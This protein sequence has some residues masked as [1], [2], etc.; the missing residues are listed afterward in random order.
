MKLTRL[1]FS[2][3]L[4]AGS[5]GSALAQTTVGPIGPNAPIVPFVNP[6]D[7]I[8]IAPLGFPTANASFATPALLSGV[9]GYNNQGVLATGQS[10]TFTN[11][12]W[13]IIAQSSGTIATLTL[14]AS[15]TPGDGQLNCYF[16]IAATT[17]LTWNANTGQSI[18]NAPTAGVANTRY[19]MVYVKAT[20]T[21]QRT[22]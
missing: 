9:N 21:W 5:L 8:W 6:T 10:L 1:L 16:N 13:S 18:A 20:N 2:A 3:A 22:Q 14:T 15:A 11:T 4:L 17:A 7:G 19:C 12:Q